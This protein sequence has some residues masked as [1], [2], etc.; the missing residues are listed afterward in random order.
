MSWVELTT[1]RA[2]IR[3]WLPNR[4]RML[5]WAGRV[6]QFGVWQLLSQAIQMITGFLVVRW[7]SYEAYAQYGLALGFQNMLNVLVDL[8]FS[9][10]IVALV[11]ERVHNREVV[12]RYI[13]SAWS[14]RTTMLIMLAPLSALAFVWFSRAHHWPVATSILLFVSII[15][16]LFFQGWASA[17][18]PPLLM[19]SEIQQ[20]YQ[21]QVLLSTGKLGVCFILNLLSCLGAAAICW[22]NVFSA[23][24][25]GYLYRSSAARHITMPDK[26]DKETNREMRKYLAPLI[27]GMIFYAFQGQIQ[28][29]LISVF[30]QNHSIAEVVALGRVSQLFIFF[31][32]FFGTIVTPYIAR[33][34]LAQLALRYTQA[35]ILT[36][37]IA[38][39]LPGSAFL[40]P[41]V[42]LW[43]LGPKYHGLHLEL[44]FSLL[45]SSL[46]FISGALYTLNNARQWVYHWTGIAYILGV[47]LIQTV[48]VAT[49]N[50]TTTLNVIIF[51]IV[52]TAYPIIVL[53]VTAVYGYRKTISSSSA[54][55]RTI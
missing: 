2:A 31:G 9:G 54:I 12:G 13:Q 35:I 28:V 41:G 39:L 14:Q 11:G 53:I 46:T 15:A 25:T 49:M 3:S 1:R 37:V 30:G 22:L 23:I 51:S 24:V 32:S 34:P 45:A 5:F 47:I 7:L 8:G 40:F 10:S 43:L 21:P 6:G 36:V 27:P 38:A 18:Y 48:L 16:F 4:E 52:T 55:E 17:Y 26:P 29:F 33:V 44:G 50:L 42:F 20:L 19:H